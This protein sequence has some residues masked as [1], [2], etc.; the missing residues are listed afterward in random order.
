MSESDETFACD[1]PQSQG[2]EL[3]NIKREV[4]FVKAAYISFVFLPNQRADWVV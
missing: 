2:P 4:G 3:S 1:S